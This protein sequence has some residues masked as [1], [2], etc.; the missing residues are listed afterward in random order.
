MSIYN[1][2][3][4]DIDLSQYIDKYI[5]FVNIADQCGLSGQLK[6][7]QEFYV[8][9]KKNVMVIGCP[10][11]DFK[12]LSIQKKDLEEWCSK[13]HRVTFPMT[14]PIRVNGVETHKLYTYLKSRALGLFG[15]EYIF[16][17]F[18][19]FLV[20]PNEERIVRFSPITGVNKI[21]RSK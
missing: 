21:L 1:I 7:I 16:W 8:Q 5:L 4:S 3:I 2:K 17:N 13:H 6:Q 9:N 18:T 19:K 14:D 11:N 15:Q 10:S 20:F 12:Q